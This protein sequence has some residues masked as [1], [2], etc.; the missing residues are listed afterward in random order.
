MRP[1][2]PLLALLALSCSQE[3]RPEAPTAAESERL[4]EA[5]AMLDRLANEEGPEAEAPSPS[6]H[7]EMNG[8]KAD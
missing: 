7:S 3:E 4:D 8:N 6:S 2:L 1:L 5:E